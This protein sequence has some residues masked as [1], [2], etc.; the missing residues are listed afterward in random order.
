MAAFGDV[1]CCCG[2]KDYDE[3]YDFHHINPAEKTFTLG[4]GRTTHTKAEIANEAKKMLYDLCKL[5]QKTY[6]WSL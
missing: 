1:C 6:K 5:P 2:T 3:V 4:S